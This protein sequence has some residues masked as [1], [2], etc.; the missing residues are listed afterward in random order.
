MDKFN[1]DTIKTTSFLIFIIVM[2][3]IIASIL[4]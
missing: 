2:C 1:I 4:N 3:F